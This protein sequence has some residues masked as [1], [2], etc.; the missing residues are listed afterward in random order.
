MV[1]YSRPKPIE[2]LGRSNV[3]QIYKMFE[4]ELMS[5]PKLDKIEKMK[6]R[7]KITDVLKPALETRNPKAKMILALVDDKLRDV[8]RLFF[9]E[10]EF[11]NRLERFLL[12][13]LDT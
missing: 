11:R 1:E 4:R 10:Y 2:F 12:E 6:I 9:D 8:L 7:K 5:M 13:K 3:E